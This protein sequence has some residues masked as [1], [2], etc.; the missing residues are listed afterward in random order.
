MSGVTDTKLLGETSCFLTWYTFQQK[1]GVCLGLYNEAG[2]SEGMM[3]SYLFSFL[4]GK[5]Y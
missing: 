3:F 2:H 4:K 5:I 1:S